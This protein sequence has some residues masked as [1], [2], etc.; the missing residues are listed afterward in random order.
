MPLLPQF[1]T[2]AYCCNCGFGPYNLNISIYDSCVQCYHR[3][4]GTCRSEVV[5]DPTDINI[6]NWHRPRAVRNGFASDG[7]VS[8][9]AER[10]MQ[11]EPTSPTRGLNLGSLGALEALTID[12]FILTR[13]PPW[14]PLSSGATSETQSQIIPLNQYLV[15][16][17]QQTF[18]A[19]IDQPPGL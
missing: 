15:P 7:P 18:T 16:R 9:P 5:R 17:D 12:P 10:P 19:V 13:D 8:V 4:C 2:V 6:W 14:N 3:F 11:R 1:S